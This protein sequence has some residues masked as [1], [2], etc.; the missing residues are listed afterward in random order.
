MGYYINPPDVT[1]EDWLEKHGAKADHNEIVLLVDA[2]PSPTEVFS[3]LVPVCLVDNGVF[4]A[5]GIA[6]DARE[7]GHML[8]P[9]GRPKKW[10]LVKRETLKPYCAV[11]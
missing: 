2:A 5:A 6:Y 9:C 4:T 8:H 10:Y 1:K 7:A 3:D 11:L